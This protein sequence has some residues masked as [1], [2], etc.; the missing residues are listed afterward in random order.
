MQTAT[1]VASKTNNVTL[2]Q[3]FT[4]REGL[5]INF[6]FE[7]RVLPF[8]ND[9]DTADI[10]NCGSVDLLQDM[11]DTK[12]IEEHL[13]GME[14]A[15]KNAFTLNQVWANI[16]AQP[17]GIDGKMLTNGYANVF[18]CMGENEVLF[19]VHVFWDYEHRMWSVFDY[20]LDKFD[21]LHDE[22]MDIDGNAGSR[23]FRN[24]R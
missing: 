4:T 10:S 6:R 11:N 17:N 20:G 9:G 18:Y 13:G 2:A 19:A 12:I 22:D 24:K 21:W 16:Q 5:F 23:V 1:Q 3:R 14:Q 8:H 15:K 7:T